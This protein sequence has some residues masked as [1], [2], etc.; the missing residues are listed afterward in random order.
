MSRRHRRREAFTLIEVLLVLVILVILGSL[1]GIQI[2][3]AQKKGLVNAAKSQ[4]SMFKTPLDMYQLDLGQYPSSSS[5]LDALRRAPGDVQ[6]TKWAGPYLE[7]DA[8]LDPWG[9]KYHYANPGKHNTDG[10]DLWSSGPDGADGTDD[11][12]GNWQ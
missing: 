4:V 11:D 9:R 7:K 3:R 10:Y 2:R 6:D 12:V 8:P 1:V 5:G